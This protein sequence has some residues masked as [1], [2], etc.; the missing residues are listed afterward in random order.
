MLNHFLVLVG[1]AIGAV[2]RY[3]IGVALRELIPAYPALGTL[4]VNVIGSMAIGYALGLPPQ[5]KIV[6]D[7]IR[8]F[9]LIGVLGGL[10]TFSS[11]AYET[12]AMLHD[13]D[14]SK[15]VGLGHLSA[16]L[17]FGLGAVWFGA[18]AASGFRVS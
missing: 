17:I 9:F 16:N 7:S 5:L 6:S 4:A 11:L 2:L 13:H 14:I 3:R 18:W 1:G 12:M 10:T 8:L 15:F